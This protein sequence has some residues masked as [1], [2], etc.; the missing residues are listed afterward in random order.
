MLDTP[1]NSKNSNV[2]T[3][4]EQLFNSTFDPVHMELIDQSHLH[5]GNRQETH[6]KLILVSM[7]FEGL[8][9]VKRHQ[10]LY[11]TAE[12]F[13]GQPVHALALHLFSPSEW[14]ADHHVAHSPACLGGSH[15]S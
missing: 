8:S 3:Q 2:K 5:S 13:I 7:A 11:K 10:M 15:A 4:L 14:Q 12:N 1:S 9:L 6:F